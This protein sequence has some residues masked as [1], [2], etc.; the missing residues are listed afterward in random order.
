MPR[1]GYTVQPQATQFALASYDRN[2]T[3]IVSVA[4]GESPRIYVGSELVR[5]GYAGFEKC[6]ES[7]KVE[8]PSRISVILVLDKAVPSGVSQRLTN[9]VLSHGFTCSYAGVPAL[10]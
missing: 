1:F 5:G 6:L 7:W 10:E 9:M 3:H 2:L 4:P 8:H